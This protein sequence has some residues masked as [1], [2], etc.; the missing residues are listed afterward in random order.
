[1][2]LSV[3]RETL[4]KSLRPMDAVADKRTTVAILANV[5]LVAGDNMLTLTATDNDISVQDSIE[6]FVETQGTTTVQAHKLT[7]IIQKTPEGV[8]VGLELVENGNRLA[9]TAGKSRFSLACLPA[10]AFPDM[11]T[12]TGGKSFTIT[13][14]VLAKALTKS[15]FAA[16]SDETRAYL[17]GIYMHI[18]ENK[19]N[20]LR[21]VSTDGHRL[22]QVDMP[23]PEGAKG[24]TGVILPRKFVGDLK[25]LAEDTKEVKLTVTDNKVQAEAG[26]V[27][28]TSKVIDGT[29]P[30]YTRVIPQDNK[31][32]MAVARRH[33]LQA[34]DRVAILSHE[35][36]RSVKFALGQ[37]ELTIS[38]NNPD[39]E[40]ASEEVRVDYS[41][42]PLE[43]GFN[44]RYVADIG[45]QVEGDDMQFFFKDGQSPVLIT[46]AA[47]G[48]ALFV[49]MPMR[50]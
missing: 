41:E 17:T 20:I 39:Q 38:A 37:D 42:S 35:K 8:M 2:K 45:Q 3:S 11:A 40:K 49:V 32:K 12:V 50:V 18:P 29:F 47:D 48:G 30:D 13:G 24:M 7:E 16:S 33:L 4:F 36:S 15:Q 31:M 44:A 14:T 21:F 19:D 46:D 43:V 26:S 23:M 6:A 25:K 27:V 10:D 1:M 22:A 28:L 9:L 34:V 5:K